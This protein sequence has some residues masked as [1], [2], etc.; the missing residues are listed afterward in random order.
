M[1][2]KAT[3]HPLEQETSSFIPHLDSDGKEKLKNNY[4][5]AAELLQQ[6]QDVLCTSLARGLCIDTNESKKCK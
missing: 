4:P 3:C 6:G 2:G 1:Q 5:K